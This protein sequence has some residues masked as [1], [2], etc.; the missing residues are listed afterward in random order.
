MIGIR[1][2][3]ADDAPSLARMINNFNV[4]EGSP[5]R[6]DVTLVKALCFRPTSSYRAFV[7]E[8]GDDL[9]GY[10][11]VMRYFDTDPCAWCTYMQDLFVVAPCRS[12]HV[13]RRLLAR[14]AKATIDWGHH[15]LAWHVRDRNRRGRAFY[16]T[17]G[18]EEQTA[19]TM[20]L[21]GDALTALA[22]DA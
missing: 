15:E 11:M 16:A 10:A 17:I 13:G 1:E 3:C 20:T 14:V 2:S 12:Q 19:L 7:A 9:V 18:G 6:V 22:K 21:G 5:G 8:D 4:E